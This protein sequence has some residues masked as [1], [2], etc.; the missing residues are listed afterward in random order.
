MPAKHS[1]RV[2]SSVAFCPRG[3]RDGV[4]RLGDRRVPP[5]DRDREGVLRVPPGDLEERRGERPRGEGVRL[6]RR[7][8]AAWMAARPDVC[9]DPRAATGSII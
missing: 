9:L 4:R 7:E 8:A 2:F 3:D 5:G 1:C 6:M